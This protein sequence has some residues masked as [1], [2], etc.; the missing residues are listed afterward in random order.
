MLESAPFG[1]YCL[2][3]AASL[4]LTKE[5]AGVGPNLGQVVARANLMS[6]VFVLPVFKVTSPPRRVN[7][8]PISV[9]N[10]DKRLAL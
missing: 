4:L 7:W 9:Y 8:A 6:F 10:S 3:T 1:C 2:S 5:R